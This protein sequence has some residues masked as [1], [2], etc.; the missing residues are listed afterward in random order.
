MFSTD[1]T[2]L[3]EFQHSESEGVFNIPSLTGIKDIHAPVNFIGFDKAIAIRKQDLG[4]HFYLDDYRF[5][6]FW[7]NPYRYIP[8]LK[9]FSCALTPDFSLYVDMPKAMQ[10][11]NIYRSRLL[12]QMMQ[13]AGI[14]V[15]PS[16]SWS[17]HESFAFCFDG[18]P[19]KSVVSVSNVGVLRN[20]EAFQL[21]KD[22]LTEMIAILDPTAIIFYGKKMTIDRG[23]IALYNYENTNFRWK[24]QKSNVY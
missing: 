17:N 4:V 21:F 22:G 8:I 11:W 5:E 1:C 9:H 24:N 20:K 13:R 3:N 2:L 23:D 15:I 7:K 14:T 12:G 18:L 6:R 19:R 16:V 10:I